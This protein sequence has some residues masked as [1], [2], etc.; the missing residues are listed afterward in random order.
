MAP[1]EHMLPGLVTGSRSQASK[2]E[3]SCD[4]SVTQPRS[5]APSLQ[6]RLSVPTFL[7]FLIS[8]LLDQDQ[9]LEPR[10]N[11]WFLNSAENGE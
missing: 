1:V 4:Q 10:E 9:R 7:L 2:P 5:S 8:T 11:L 6:P 3:A